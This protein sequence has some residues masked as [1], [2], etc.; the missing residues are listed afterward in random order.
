MVDITQAIIPGRLPEAL[1]RRT[2]DFLSKLA[3]ILP[4]LKIHLPRLRRFV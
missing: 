2:L 1:S 3:E 4:K